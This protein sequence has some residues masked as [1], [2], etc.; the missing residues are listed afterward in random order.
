MR[1]LITVA[2]VLGLLTPAGCKKDD[3]GAAQRR[4][5]A[6]LD[7]ALDAWVRGEPPERVEGVRVDDP[8]WRA[9][10][11]LVSFLV[12]R[13]DVVEGA[14]DEVRCRVALTLQDRSGRRV[15]REVEYRVRLAEPVSVE[16]VPTPTG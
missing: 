14:K 10:R 8:D 7:R 12:S 3:A 9:G 2:L 5:E 11:R 15:D 13:S 16:R 6:A 1:S 4:A